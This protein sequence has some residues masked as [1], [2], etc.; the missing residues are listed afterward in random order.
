VPF[1]D[2][3]E[4]STTTAPRTDPTPRHE[5]DGL[6]GGAEA[7]VA[8]AAV[9]LPLGALLDVAGSRE[10]LALFISRPSLSNSWDDPGIEAVVADALGRQAESLAGPAAPGWPAPAPVVQETSLRDWSWSAPADPALL[11]PALLEAALVPVR[12]EEGGERVGDLA[13]RRPD[14]ETPRPVLLRGTGRRPNAGTESP[15]GTPRAPSPWVPL[16]GLLAQ[17]IYL[18]NLKQ[19]EAAAEAEPGVEGLQAPGDVRLL[20]ADLIQRS[21]EV[22]TQ[23]IQSFYALFLGREAAP[24]EAQGWVGMLLAGRTQEDVLGAFLSTREFYDRA[25]VLVPSGTPDERY[26]QA[27]HLVLLH[28]SALPQEVSG[29]LAALS[30]PGAVAGRAVLPSLLVRSVEYRTQQVEAL[31]RS[32]L[33]RPAAAGEAAAWACS[34]F[35]LLS[36]RTF[37]VGRSAGA[38]KSPSAT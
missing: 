18:G 1:R 29:Y 31:Y 27:L 20:V 34:P 8:G 32:V 7:G 6:S 23:L 2:D 21:A 30:G 35:D 19:P 37:L 15:P 17:V 4:D 16:G 24:G 11:R 28:R 9:T 22:F 25:G 10:V 38:S 36:V 3:K 13:L 26:V 14:A 12:L 33:G 5:F